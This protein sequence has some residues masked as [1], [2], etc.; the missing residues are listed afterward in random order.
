[1]KIPEKTD[2]EIGMDDQHAVACHCA[3]CAEEARPATVL[4]V[5]QTAGLALVAMGGVTGEVDISLIDNVAP[6]VVLLIQ[7]GVAVGHFGEADGRP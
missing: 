3:L 1:M 4:S 7:G 2:Q 5:D 6:G